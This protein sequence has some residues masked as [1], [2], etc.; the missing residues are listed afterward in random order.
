MVGL[1]F[2]TREAELECFDDL[3]YYVIERGVCTGC[4]TCAGICPRI[5]F[6]ND[7]PVMQDE[8]DPH[9]NSCTQFCPQFYVPFS[10]MEEMIFGAV[11]ND[12]YLGYVDRVVSARANSDAIRGVS[13]DGGVTTTL[14]KYLLESGAVE[15]V[16]MAGVSES[17]PLKPVPIVATTGDDVVSAAG[18]RYSICPVVMGLREAFEKGIKK[19]AIVGTPCQVQGI[20]KVELF[21]EDRY[22]FEIKAVIGIFCFENFLYDEFFKNFIEKELGIELGEINSV[23][24]RNNSF[25]LHKN[26]EIESIPLKTAF[27]HVNIPCTLCRDFSA[28]LSDISI[29]AIGAKTD[30]NAVII[31]SERGRRLFDELVEKN[32]VTLASDAVDLER[33]KRLARRKKAHVERTSAETTEFLT[34]F[35][36]AEDK[37]KIYELLIALHGPRLETISEA[38]EMD[39]S[40]IRDAL[41]SLKERSWIRETMDKTTNTPRYIPEKPETVINNEVKKLNSKLKIAKKKAISELNS[42]YTRRIQEKIEMQG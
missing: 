28:E 20:R 26:G 30:W 40:V 36:T 37:V 7:R 41:E 31:R 13:Q 34:H 42:S 24:I 33:I 38:T 16:I 8:Y 12:R 32:L 9:C 1:E 27:K 15:G 14:T 23:R 22:P 10:R 17:E 4:G 19:I 29:G 5:G 21:S 25:E 39:D 6:E 11:R 18:S 35:G 2:D 3:E